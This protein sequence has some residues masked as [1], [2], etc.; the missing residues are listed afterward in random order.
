MADDC[1]AQTRTPLVF[2]N[3]DF[4][5]K[6]LPAFPLFLS[7]YAYLCEPRRVPVMFILSSLRLRS[8]R[9]STRHFSDF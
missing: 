4:E 1:F 7:S 8:L 9:Y 6:T 3:Y 5:M 2:Q